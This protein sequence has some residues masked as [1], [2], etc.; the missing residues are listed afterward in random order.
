MEDDVTAEEGGVDVDACAAEAE[1]V[2]VDMDVE[3]RVLCGLCCVRHVLPVAS[4]GRVVGEF[5][6]RREDGIWVKRPQSSMEGG[7][8]S[9]FLWRRRGSRGAVEY[10]RHGEK[11]QEEGPKK[12]RCVGDADGID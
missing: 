9:V 2:G 1:D 11:K 6:G 5:W 8:Q 4:R 7:G 10:I 3:E 12:G